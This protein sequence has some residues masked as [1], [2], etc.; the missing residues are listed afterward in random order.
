MTLNKEE[1]LRRLEKAGYESYLVGGFVRDKIMG[2]ASSDVDISTKARPD[3][4]EEIFKDLKILDVGKKFGTI[5]VIGHGQEY[6]ITTFRKDFSY[7]DK[8][9]PGQVVFADNIES[10]LER[11]DFTINAM[12][13]RNGELIDHFGGQKDIKEKII[14]AVGNPYERISEDYLRALRAVRFAANLGFD[15]EK[16]LQE[17]IK[18]NSKNLAYISVERQAAELD[19]ILIGPDPARGIRLLDKLGLLEEIFPEVKE[20][21]GFNQHSPHHYLDCFDHSLKVLEGTPPD[22]VTRLAALFHDIGKPATF[23]LDEDGNGRFFGHQKISQEL[24]EKRLKYLK[25]PK[26][27]IEDVGILIG[28]HMDSSNPYTE[29]SVARLLRRLGEDNLKRLFDLQEADILAT[30]HEDIS[31]IEKGRILLKEILE[32]KPVLSRKDLAING[33]DLIGLGFNEGPLVGEILK[34]IERRVFEENLTNDRD[35]LLTLARNLGSR[36][37]R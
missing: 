4:I 36:L 2:R 11:R 13:L 37:D 1:V 32:R 8:R 14:R 34:E 15:I 16:N 22:L 18:K 29:K 24:A 33:K 19:K 7:K 21:V 10:D 3:Q 20:M 9:R 23:F 5:R 31:N 25:Y 35:T 12:A 6:E 28:R 27:I 30:V 26:K 17:A